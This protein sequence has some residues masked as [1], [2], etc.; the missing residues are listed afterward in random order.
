MS[1]DNSADSFQDPDS[2]LDFYK[3][4]TVAAFV[5]LS[6]LFL[7]YF[8]AFLIAKSESE[9]GGLRPS[10]SWIKVNTEAVS[11]PFGL[12]LSSAVAFAG[13]LVAIKLSNN[14][15]RLTKQSGKQQAE[16]MRIDRHQKAIEICSIISP[17]ASEVDLA[18]RQVTDAILTGL[19][20]ASSHTNRLL[21][22]LADC[23][24]SDNSVYPP[25]TYVTRTQVRNAVTEL[26]LVLHLSGILSGISTGL[27]RLYQ[28]YGGASGIDT[29]SLNWKPHSSKL[30]ERFLL[31]YSRLDSSQSAEWDASIVD[32]LDHRP[33]VQRL[34]DQVA[35]MNPRET[36][37]YLRAQAG[38]L[39]AD[40]ITDAFMEY[41]GG[42]V[43]L[44]SNPEALVGTGGM[45]RI[46][47]DANQLFFAALF[48]LRRMSATFGYVNPDDIDIS[49]ERN[50]YYYRV[51]TGIPVMLKVLDSLPSSHAVE[52]EFS[53]LTVSMTRTFESVKKSEDG[54]LQEYV[55]NFLR[56]HTANHD[57]NRDALNN[58]RN[59]L[60]ALIEENGG[61]DTGVFIVKQV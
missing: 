57:G 30:Q 20:M 41:F 16:Q 31:E 47:E 4:L 43:H 39:D 59:Q 40:S 61:I 51:N 14:A 19:A 45:N 49:T 28:S 18:A 37:A 55:E 17:V 26:A 33:K 29:A 58:I 52:K 22:E 35:Q 1:S 3:Y 36:A 5:V 21:A 8:V 24:E 12:I 54:S 7:W 48:G 10:L 6:L 13:S 9:L 44:G 25:R 42:I 53:R 2:L 56:I 34:L 11:A 32:G 46:S 60:I 27:F 50:V 38:A 23:G 15:L